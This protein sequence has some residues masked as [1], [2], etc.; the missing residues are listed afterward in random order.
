MT[1][2][3]KR[4]APL[5]LL[6][7]T[8]DPRS[9]SRPNTDTLGSNE[10]WPKKN[11]VSARGAA[12]RWEK[13]AFEFHQ[14]VS[15]W[16]SERM[17]GLGGGV[18]RRPGRTG[19]VSTRWSSPGRTRGCGRRRHIWCNTPWA[20]LGPG[21]WPTPSSSRRYPWRTPPVYPQGSL[22]PHPASCLL[23]AGACSLAI[24]KEK[25]MVMSVRA[26]SGKHDV[27]NI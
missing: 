18:S 5:H 25:K 20:W 6:G 10:H 8:T 22:A 27:I 21:R 7:N 2:P 4:R 26:S 16:T 9:V 12:Y 23:A 24:T 1:E 14:M 19:T 3:S 17:V 13:K 11:G 15:H